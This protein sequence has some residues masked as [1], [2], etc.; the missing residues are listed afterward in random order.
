M[1]SAP[2]QPRAS[3]TSEMT[4]CP[5]MMVASPAAT[6][7]L[8]SENATPV[9]IMIPSAPAIT[10]SSDCHRRD[11]DIRLA[12]DDQQHDQDQTG[13]HTSDEVGQHPGANTADDGT[14]PAAQRG[15][16]ANGYPREQCADHSHEQVCTQPFP[17]ASVIFHLI[18]FLSMFSADFLHIILDR[19]QRHQPF[20]EEVVHQVDDHRRG[21]FQPHA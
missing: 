6:P 2:P 11:L 8:C 18:A 17:P 7:A 12:V 16:R 14:H 10:N 3:A 5:R 19:R 21:R 4:I 13:E 1:G 9:M 15:L 20:I